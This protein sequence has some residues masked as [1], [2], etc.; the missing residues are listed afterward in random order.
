MQDLWSK[1]SPIL[2]LA[3][4]NFYRDLRH[5]AEL[6]YFLEGHDVE[7]LKNAQ[8]N[9]W[10]RAILDGF[11]EAYHERLVRICAAHSRIGMSQEQFCRSYRLAMMHVFQ[12]I[13]VVNK[14]RPYRNVEILEALIDAVMTDM[15]HSITAFSNEVK[16]N[17]QQA[18]LAVAAHAEDFS[19]NSETV[20]AEVDQVSD[21][22]R[23]VTASLDEIVRTIQ[24][25]K[26][27]VEKAVS[28][29]SVATNA[30]EE[31]S[32]KSNEIGAFLNIIT[33]IADKTKLLA[34]NAAI[35]AARAGEEGKGFSVVA[36]EV[37]QLAE[38]TETGARDVAS[39]LG[40]IQDAVNSSAGIIKSMSDGFGSVLKASASLAE[41]MNNQQNAMHD[42]QNRIINMRENLAHQTKEMQMLVQKFT[43]KAS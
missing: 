1:I 20:N 2:E 32:E 3:L 10:R 37:R 30:M 29:S 6:S 4:E 13:R 36:D 7:S 25:T 35:E 43:V 23:S 41:L 33:E 34:L 15:E 12:T 17:E 11:D 19:R 21:A 8:I 14:Y 38:G 5:D 26:D 40:E 9:H 28:D 31:L 27:I 42:M 24:S 39:R 22:A 18:T 16:Q